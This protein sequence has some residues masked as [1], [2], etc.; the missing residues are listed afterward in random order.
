MAENREI[1]FDNDRGTFNVPNAHRGP[2]VRAASRAA[3]PLL[4][5][6]YGLHY[7][8]L[9][10]VSIYRVYANQLG[11]ACDPIPFSSLEAAEAYLADT[12]APS[13]THIAAV[14]SPSGTLLAEYCSA[15]S[16]RS[17]WRK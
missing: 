14:Y 1:V 16:A 15:N 3:N 9:Y 12:T 2:V 5:R 13:G 17:A 11:R 4:D 6:E 7:N 10:T 8:D